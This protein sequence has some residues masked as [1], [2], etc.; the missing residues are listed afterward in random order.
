[1]AGMPNST[2][3]PF[4]AALLASARAFSK[5]CWFSSTW[6][7]G[8]ISS[9]SSRPS[10]SSFMAAMATAGAVLRPKGSSRIAWVANCWVCSC[11][12]T[13][14]RCSLLHTRTGACMPSKARRLMV[15]WNRVSSPVRARNCLGNCLRERGQRREPL[16]PERITGIM[17]VLLK[18]LCIWL[19]VSRPLAGGARL[20]R[21]NEQHWGHHSKTPP[22]EGAVCMSVYCRSWLLSGCLVG[23]GWALDPHRGE[24]A[25][26][27][28]D[29]QADHFATGQGDGLE[30][31]DLLLAVEQRQADLDRVDFAIAVAIR[32]DLVD[33]RG[34]AV[35]GLQAERAVRQVLHPQQ[36]FLL[37]LEGGF[38]HQLGFRARL[39]DQGVVAVG[40]EFHRQAAAA[41]LGA[42]AAGREEAEVAGAQRSDVAQVGVA[43]A[44]AQFAVAGVIGADEGRS[45]GRGW[46]VEATF[47]GVGVQGAEAQGDGTGVGRPAAFGLSVHG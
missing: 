34:L 20:P 29:V 44:D 35:G 27:T 9:S 21:L 13:I 33:H 7:A 31:A 43:D 17:F 5:A 37:V 23:L 30:V 8:R 24:L 16:P 14:K 40:V 32:G 28:G 3:S 11:S 42:V 15:C 1:M 46:G 45:L 19:D 25:A 22:H 4:S 10:A 36:G 41:D 38:F 12:W 26:A 2:I 39:V 18:R 47:T 6:S